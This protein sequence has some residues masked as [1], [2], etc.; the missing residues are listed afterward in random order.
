MIIENENFHKKIYGSEFETKLIKIA[1]IGDSAICIV[2]GTVTL[3]K[4]KSI[5]YKGINISSDYG[6]IFYKW[7]NVRRIYKEIIRF[8]Y[9]SKEVFLSKKDIISYMFQFGVDRETALKDMREDWD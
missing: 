5:S 2:W 7:Y 8:N 9:N 1:N 6:D 4:I 3:G